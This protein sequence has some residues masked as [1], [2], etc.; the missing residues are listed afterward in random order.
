MKYPKEKKLLGSRGL[1]K[2]VFRRLPEGGFDLNL[3]AY[4]PL[5]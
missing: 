1:F 2:C 4:F 3:G 5:S